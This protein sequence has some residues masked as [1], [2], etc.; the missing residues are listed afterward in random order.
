MSVLEA[1][2]RAMRSGRVII[3]SEFPSIQREA[4]A[5]VDLSQLHPGDYLLR[6]EDAEALR[7]ARFRDEAEQRAF[8]VSFLHQARDRVLVQLQN[9]ISAI[10]AVDRSHRL[11]C[12]DV[13]GVG[14]A[15]QYASAS[16]FA[17]GSFRTWVAAA[18]GHPGFSSGLI[19]FLGESLPASAFLGLPGTDVGF[20]E[21]QLL[22]GI[23]FTTENFRDAHLPADTRLNASTIRVLYRASACA[24]GS[25]LADCR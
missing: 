7:G 6:G 12:F 3:P 2:T 9:S 21:I 15:A 25:T 5:A 13:T 10:P 17:S 8:Y 20:S 24:E 4:L 14:A 1:V 19:R 11:G 22:D 23:Q 16:C 18:E